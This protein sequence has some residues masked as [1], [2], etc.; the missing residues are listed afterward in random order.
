MKFALLTFAASVAHAW[1]LQN[2][3]RE[4][5]LKAA[6]DWY[7]TG[8]KAKEHESKMLS[9]SKEAGCVIFSYWTRGRAAAVRTH[10]PT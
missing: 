8:D 9:D 7:C 1:N 10:T 6:L 4:F 3:W 2:A 5:P